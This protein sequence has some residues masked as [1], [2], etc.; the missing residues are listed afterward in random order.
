VGHEAF[1][2]LKFFYGFVI[3]RAKRR[4]KGCGRKRKPNRKGMARG[5]RAR[6]G[7]GKKSRVLKGSRTG[8]EG[9]EDE[10]AR[11]GFDKKSRGLKEAERE[12]KGKRRKVR[13]WGFGGGERQ[14]TRG[15]AK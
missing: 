12:G 4:K 6:V 5:G 8:R 10:G 7:F 13:E 9:Q 14:T 3:E 1:E 2:H 11:V 15:G